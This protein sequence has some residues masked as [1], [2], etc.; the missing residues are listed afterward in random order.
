MIELNNEERRALDELARHPDGC[1]E[2]VLLADGSTI[3]QLSGL[4]IDGYAGLQRKR[5]QVGDREKTVLWM[6]IT[7]AGRNAIAG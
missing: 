5:V 6:Q 7:E 4:V 2:A 3:R 1:A